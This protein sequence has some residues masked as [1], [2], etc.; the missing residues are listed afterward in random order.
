MG[1]INSGFPRYTFAFPAP[2]G[3]HQPS[4]ERAPGA[5]PLG[6]KSPGEEK[7]GEELEQEPAMG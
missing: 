2:K 5:F 4:D 7:K 6:E 1:E 3:E